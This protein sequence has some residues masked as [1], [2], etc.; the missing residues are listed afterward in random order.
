M[1]AI[2]KYHSHLFSF[3]FYKLILFAAEEISTSIY[4]Y[5]R[6]LQTSVSEL[7]IHELYIYI[8]NFREDIEKLGMLEFARKEKKYN[9]VVGEGNC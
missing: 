7:I 2:K 9:A 4:K 3:Y 1:M 5:F 8:K 6:E